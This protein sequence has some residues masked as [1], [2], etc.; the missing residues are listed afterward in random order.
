MSKKEETISPEPTISNPKDLTLSPKSSDTSPENSMKNIFKRKSTQDL[1]A[2][3]KRDLGIS[4]FNMKRA[5]QSVG[6]WII[7]VENN[8]NLQMRSDF[9]EEKEFKLKKQKE[10]QSHIEELSQY[11]N[12]EIKITYFNDKIRSHK[13]L[14]KKYDEIKD[15]INDKIR[16]IKSILPELENKII[17]IKIQMKKL[18]KEN[19]KLM[20]QVNN[21]ENELSTRL[22]EDLEKINLN[23]D[24]NNFEES[25]N[26]NNSGN[27][28]LTNSNNSSMINNSI[29]ISDILEKNEEL[30]KKKEKNVILREYLRDRKNENDYIIKNINQMNNNFF[31]CKR[32]YR[33]GMY[34][35]AKELLRI[36]EIELDK[37]I[38]NSNTNFNSLYFD[39]YKTNYNSKVNSDLFKKS[40]INDNIKKKFKYPIV[41]KAQP[42]DLL[43]KVV[44]NIIDENNTSNK[45]NNIKKNK[46]SWEEFKDFSAYQIYT[47]LNIN[48]EVLDKLDTYIFN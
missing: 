28:I 37:V 3:Y 30:K 32:I 35:I 41:E 21:F 34:E 20:E 23:L 43:Y 12:G 15:K 26:L 7:N 47:L 13:E 42:N 1:Y 31:R 10:I 8:R 39:I 38:N 6:Q 2:S 27:S 24:N 45:I 22:E 29:N 11:Y 46:F 33:E 44:K 48:K 25:K 5:I 36:N 14:C 16:N 40:I 19:L 17:N 9:D 4:H 18:N